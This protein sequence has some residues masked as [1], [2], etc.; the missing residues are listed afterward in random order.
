MAI[1]LFMLARQR[2]P[3]IAD[4]RYGYGNNADGRA[5][6]AGLSLG[7]AGGVGALLISATRSP[8]KISAFR[9]QSTQS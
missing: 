7:I 8:P 4:S 1:S 5:L 9:S 2:A 3:S 6:S